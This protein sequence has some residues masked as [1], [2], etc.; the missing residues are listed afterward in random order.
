MSPG[1]DNTNCFQ[2]RGQA[3]PAR[4]MI[5]PMLRKAAIFVT[6]DMPLGKPFP[7]IIP[8]VSTQQH[9]YQAYSAGYIRAQPCKH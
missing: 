1:A 5:P 6:C 2:A 7:L 9:Y 3:P 8:D 4:G